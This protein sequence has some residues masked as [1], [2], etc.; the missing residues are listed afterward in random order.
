MRRSFFSLA[1][2]ILIAVLVSAVPSWADQIMPSYT[3]FGGYSA[4]AYSSPPTPDMG[5]VTTNGLSA[6]LT[7]STSDAAI[8]SLWMDTGLNTTAS[9]LTL[10]FYVNVLSQAPSGYAQNFGGA[11]TLAGMRIWDATVNN[12]AYSLQLMPTSTTTGY[13]AFR[14][15]A[16]DGVESIATYSTNTLYHVRLESDYASGKANAYINGSLAY[17]G[18]PLRGVTHAGDLTGENFFYM[19]GVAGANNSIYIADPSAVPLPST[20]SAGLVSLATLGL[21]KVIRDRSKKNAAMA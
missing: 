8:G 20:A 13:F 11:Q 17:S 18:Y 2:S 10:D 6:T 21:G 4:T 14:N 12:W 16:N 15:A 5:T 9:F 7:T 1:A 3:T 19:N